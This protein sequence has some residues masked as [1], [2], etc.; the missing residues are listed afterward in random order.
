VSAT[1]DGFAEAFTEWAETAS[2]KQYDAAL[3][4][5]LPS[6]LEAALDVGCGGGLLALW[7]AD[8]TGHVVALDVS[9]AMI[10]LAQRRVNATER[11]NVAFVVGDAQVPPL[12]PGSFDL[13]ISDTAIH[14]TTVELSLPAMRAL[15]RPGGRLVIRDIITHNPS[16]ARSPVWQVLGTLRS[17][18]RYLRRLGP[19]TTLRVLRFE[20]SPTWVRHRAEGAELTPDEFERVFSHHLPGCRFIHEA[21]FVTACWERAA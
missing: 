12:A 8:R 13:V 3:G 4:H 5:L 6:R 21:W 19:G 14:D 17:I 10:R 20:L 7:L 9:P 2:P 15:V 18:P 1:F 16:R 11:T